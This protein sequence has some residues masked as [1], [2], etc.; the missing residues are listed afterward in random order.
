M[1][2]GDALHSNSS[3]ATGYVPSANSFL[4]LPRVIGKIFSHSSST[5][6]YFSNVCIR[7]LLPYTC[8]MGPFCTL[9]SLILATT[10]PSMSSEC[11]QVNFIG[12][13]DTTYF[14]ASLIGFATGFFISSC[15]GQYAA[16]YHTFSDLGVGQMA[17]PFAR[18][19]LR[20]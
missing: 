13:C 9:S 4:P 11:C 16:K 12:L 17:A 15:W 3:N 20:R 14:V 19:L 10:S 5:R 1:P 18:P 2:L 8:N 6:S 7:L